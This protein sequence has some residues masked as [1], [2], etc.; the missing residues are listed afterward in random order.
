MPDLVNCLFMSLICP[1]LFKG[2]K[3]DK[4]GLTN[5]KIVSMKIYH[6]FAFVVCKVTR[7]GV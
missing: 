2:L 7:T 5:F 6:G 4:N 1:N 3:S